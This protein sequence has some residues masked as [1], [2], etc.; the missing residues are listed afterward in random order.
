MAC[1]PAKLLESGGQISWVYE[2][3][4]LDPAGTLGTLRPEVLVLFQWA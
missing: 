3:L 4:L 2:P 1:R